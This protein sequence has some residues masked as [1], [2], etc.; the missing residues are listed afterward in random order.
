MIRI[1]KK[2]DIG[3]IEEIIA[4]AKAS[5]R[6]DGV[7]QW[8]KSNPDKK[9]IEVQIEKK[10]GYVYEMDGEVYAYAFLS[11]KVEPT[12]KRFE[13]DF[14]GST[15]LVIHTFMVD[16]ASN[17]KGLGTKFMEDIVSMAENLGKDSLRIDTH[18]DNFRMRGLLDKFCFRK[19]GRVLVDEDGILKDRI[20]YEKIL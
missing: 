15:Y 1:A 14:E 20:C 6:K 9:L 3:R 4:L 18:E 7:D 19:L 10:A 5:L 16:S 17:I 11:E 2:S 8:Q 12:Y 13:N